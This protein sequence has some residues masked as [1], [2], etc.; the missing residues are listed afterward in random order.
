MA[1]ERSAPKNSG[2]TPMP[3][4]ATFATMTFRAQ[5]AQISTIKAKSRRDIW[6][7]L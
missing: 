5:I 6:R 7:S 2:G 4:T 3:L 1:P